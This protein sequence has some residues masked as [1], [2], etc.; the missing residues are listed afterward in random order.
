MRFDTLFLHVLYFIFHL[1]LF[2]NFIHE[3]MTFVTFV[4]DLRPKSINPWGNNASMDEG[5]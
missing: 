1:S 5:H 2:Y 4:H 3:G